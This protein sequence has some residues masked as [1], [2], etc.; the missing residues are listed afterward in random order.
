MALV[1][2]PADLLFF[3]SVIRVTMC[4]EYKWHL[5]ILVIPSKGEKEPR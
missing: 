4:N 3:S 5:V 2:L 1:Q